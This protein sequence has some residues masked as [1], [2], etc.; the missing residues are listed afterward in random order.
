MHTVTR[1][2]YRPALL[3]SA[4]MLALTITG[5][6]PTD[7]E[8]AADAANAD[9][10]RTEAAPTAAARAGAQ[11]VAA[12]DAADASAANASD[13]AG[14]DP[15]VA[16]G[17]AFAYRFNF[18]LPDDSVSDAQNR[19]VAACEQLGRAHCRVT[20]MRY[21]QEQGGRI[22]AH[23]TFMLDPA[24]ARS[25]TRDA[26]NIVERIDG[27]LVDSHVNGTDV[28]TGI[29]ASQ[30]NSARLGG[31]VARIE[32]RLRQPGLSASEQRDL[33]NQIAQMQG[34][35]GD[36]E[37][38]RRDGEAQLAFTPVNFTYT[39]STSVGGLDRDRPFASAWAA[40]ADSLATASAF[41]MMLLGVILPWALML[42]GV[43][44]AWRFVRRRLRGTDSPITPAVTPTTMP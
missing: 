34:A 21:E 41:V 31:D 44:F 38:D 13:V 12:E 35:L 17:V 6:S 14:A 33:R 40:S 1:S 5:C 23:L 8:A 25:F 3:L 15:S 24:R 43:M 26:V 4:A 36:E 19:H 10:A 39:G 28:G 16:P 22:D 2:K 18:R 32:E 37:A 42:G 11:A 20:G 30:A 27:E 9:A 7:D 29:T